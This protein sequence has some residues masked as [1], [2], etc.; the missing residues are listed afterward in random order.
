LDCLDAGEA[1]LR[2]ASDMV[3]LG[4]LLCGR[5]EALHLVGDHAAANAA[6]AEVKTIAHDIGAGPDSEIGQALELV[7]RLLGVEG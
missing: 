3:S 4:V 6:L 7:R 5:V 1:L 2:A